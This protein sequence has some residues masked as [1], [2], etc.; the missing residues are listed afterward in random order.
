M[1]RFTYVGPIPVVFDPPVGEV[2]PGDEFEVP[3]EMGQSFAQHGH[4]EEVG[5]PT[6]TARQ[7]QQQDQ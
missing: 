4:I 1:R 3:D 5:T 7:R 6:R 2:K